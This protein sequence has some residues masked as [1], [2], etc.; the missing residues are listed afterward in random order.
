[1]ELCY[2]KVISIILNYI[3]LPPKVI[4]SVMDLEVGLKT[5]EHIST[6]RT[7]LMY[8]VSGVIAFAHYAS[9]TGILIFSVGGMCVARC[10]SFKWRFDGVDFYPQHVRGIAHCASQSSCG[11]LS[12]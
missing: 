9:V 5:Q 2:Y 10:L 1:M 7:H 11:L 12:M 4:V 8:F 3:I 6:C